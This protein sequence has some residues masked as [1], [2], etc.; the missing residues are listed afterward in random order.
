MCAARRGV[1]PLRVDC[2]PRP[3]ASS[4]SSVS[5]QIIVFSD[6]VFA[7]KTYGTLLRR[8]FIYGETDQHERLAII[9]KFKLPNGAPGAIDCIFISKVRPHPTLTPPP[10]GVLIWDVYGLRELPFGGG[11]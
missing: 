9:Q 8:A 3:P 5:P 7:L 11:A 4:P 1:L 10:P 2:F 6:N